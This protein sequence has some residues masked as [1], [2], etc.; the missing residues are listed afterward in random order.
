MRFIGS[1]RLLL[2]NI[3]NT[4][5][6][7]IVNWR[8]LNSFCDI[9]GGTGCVGV[10]FKKF[11]KIISNDLLYFSYV[12]QKSSI[13]I[14]KEPIFPGIDNSIK[15]NVLKYL[16]E[17]RKKNLNKANFI[18]ENFSPHANCNRMYL[19]NENAL[20]IDFMRSTINSWFDKK[21]I[22]KSEYFYLLSS[23]VSA[24]PFVSN[25]AG[26]YGAY[27]KNWDKRSFKTIKL[28]K[29]NIFD[30]GKKNIVYNEDANI[31][32]DKIDGDILYLDPPYNS[33]QYMPNYHLLETIARYDSPILKGVTGIR[34]S[35]SDSKSKY[36]Q[37]STAED[38]LSEL[39]SKSRFKYV[40]L[41]YSNEGIIP[42]VNLD[43]ILKSNSKGLFV[44]NIIPY[45]RYK[46]TK[47]N[48]GVTLNEL[49]YIIKK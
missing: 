3:E 15:K 44:K 6:D 47:D 21:K 27:L 43:K 28:E 37:K 12:I 8:Q 2:T 35:S 41:S 20:K 40:I 36:C 32:I 42:E 49:M 14:N 22:S 16:N 29:P 25:I 45:R 11:F 31:L 1:K 9:F 5:K 46:R 26:T 7:N 48:I 24:V 19:T 23:I 10:H 34:Q 39:I 33:R 17:N 38:V 18:Y 13:E 30:N 4:I